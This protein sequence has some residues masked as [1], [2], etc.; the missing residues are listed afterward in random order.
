LA[1]CCGH[2]FAPLTLAASGAFFMKSSVR[3]ICWDAVT[4]LD[5]GK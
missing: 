5:W 4:S 1:L 3:D 2:L